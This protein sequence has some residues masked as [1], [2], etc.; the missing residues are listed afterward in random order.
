M[1][2]AAEAGAAADQGTMINESGTWDAVAVEGGRQGLTLVHFS[3]Q[4]EPFMT[5]YRP[6]I[7]PSTP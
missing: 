3:A 5:Q 2:A 4:P 1:E 7:P 6:Y